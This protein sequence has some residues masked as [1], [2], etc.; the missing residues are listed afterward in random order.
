MC[1]DLKHR[2]PQNSNIRVVLLFRFL[3]LEIKIMKGVYK[4]LPIM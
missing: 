2:S 3:F 1:D 4:T